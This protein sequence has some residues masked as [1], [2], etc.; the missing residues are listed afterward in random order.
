MQTKINY[1]DSDLEAEALK[2]YCYMPQT[3]LDDI[4]NPSPMF[5]AFNAFWVA[6]GIRQHFDKY[7]QPVAIIECL[8]QSSLRVCDVNR[9]LYY[10]GIIEKKVFSRF[11][12]ITSFLSLLLHFRELYY[13]PTINVYNLKIFLQFELKAELYRFIPTV[14]SWLC[15]QGGLIL[16]CTILAEVYLRI[17]YAHR[18]GYSVSKRLV[19]LTRFKISPWSCLV[20]KIYL[21]YHLRWVINFNTLVGCLSVQDQLKTA[22]Q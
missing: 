12:V 14:T 2:L 1:Y 13:N 5:Y 20:I 10:H 19:K 21:R 9:V 11:Y 4:T 6:I 7:K 15:N 8:N 22:T 17:T 16:T 18:R 3:F